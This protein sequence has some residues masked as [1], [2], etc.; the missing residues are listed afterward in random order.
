MIDTSIDRCKEI[1]QSVSDV[2][3]DNTAKKYNLN[4]ETIRR[5]VRM[6]KSIET[7]GEQITPK[8][9]SLINKLSHLSDDELSRMVNGSSKKPYDK[10]IID[11]DGETIRFL[12]L[13]D[14]HIGS[15]YFDDEKL[16]AAFDEA[17]AQGCEFM[18]HTGDLLEGMSTRP[19][20]VYELADIGYGRQRDH[21]RE[22]LKE[23]GLPFYLVGGNHSNWINTK[24]GMGIDVE[25]DLCRE[26]QYGHYLGMHEGDLELNGVKVKLWHGED[27][28][29]YATSYRVQKIIEAFTG[30]EKPHILLCGHTHKSLFIFERNVHAISTG[31]IQRQSGFMRMKK[32]ASHVGFW[33]VEMT[34]G[35]GDVKKFSP[36]WYPF[37][38]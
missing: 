12:A 22:L 4:R 11:F 37:Y 1:F 28:S 17:K 38:K 3:V 19:G 30:G 6:A 25:E 29:S 8:R 15:V 9:E 32:L 35:N 5:Y 33:I 20:H 34:V 13:G 36:T 2:G 26:F 27:G 24:G 21:A 18:L 7:P 31:C 14:T 16:I 23:W 10:Q